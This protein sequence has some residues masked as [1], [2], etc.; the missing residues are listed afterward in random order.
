MGGGKSQAEKL[1]TKKQIFR[2]LRGKLETAAQIPGFFDVGQK[3]EIEL[4]CKSNTDGKQ[5]GDCPFAQFI[6]LVL[7]KK[8]I[9]YKVIPTL[10]DKMPAGITQLPSLSVK[11]EVI[12]D[13]LA[14]AE[15]IEKSYPHTS[16][17]RQG[18][19]SYQEVLEKSASFFPTLSTFIKNKDDSKDPALQ[20]AVETQL[21]TLDEIIR[22]TPGQYM[23]GIEMTLA[24]LYLVPQLFHAMVA[25]E[26]FKDLEFYHIEGEPTRP[27]LEN[28]VARMFEMEEFNN[29]KAYYNIDQVIN[30]WKT[31]RGDKI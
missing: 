4:Y 14:I 23:C 25:M 21:D 30:G 22:S 6:Q 9:P 27:A 12:S 31:A 29:K 8:G 17:T 28:Y 18:A 5:L 15:Y 19:Y 24:D 2:D 13:S 3:V 16:L 26:H 11:G 20:A 1:M 7:L 10:N